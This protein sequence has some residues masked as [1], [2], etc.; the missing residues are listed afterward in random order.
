LVRE[1]L[2]EEG[3][4]TDEQWVIRVD[5]DELLPFADAEEMKRTWR[6]RSPPRCNYFLLNLIDR[7]AA[8][9]ELPHIQPL[10]VGG[11]MF[12]Q[13]PYHCTVTKEIMRGAR[14]KMSMHAGT[15]RT[16]PGHHTYDKVNSMEKPH[17][18]RNNLPQLNVSHFK[19]VSSVRQRLERRQKEYE[20]M[21]YYWSSESKKLLQYLRDNHSRFE[22]DKYC[23]KLDE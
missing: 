8:D 9:G 18:C 23:K 20:A 5:S 4:T 22:V 16:G 19:W 10:E 12:E 15:M 17:S 1:L 3:V 21:G 7:I 13:F 11:T 14:W 6:E 2:D